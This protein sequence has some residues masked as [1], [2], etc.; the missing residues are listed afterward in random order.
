MFSRFGHS[1]KS[2]SKTC[3]MD[4]AAH[5]WVS[6]PVSFFTFVMI[7]FLVQVMWFSICALLPHRR[8]RL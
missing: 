8:E 2:L 3:A 4:L 1:L 5:I 7:L 6:I